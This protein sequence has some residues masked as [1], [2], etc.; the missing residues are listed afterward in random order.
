[1]AAGEGS[2][3]RPLTDTTPKPLLKLCGQTLIEHNI[4]SI[5]SHFDAV[6][7]I[8]KYKKENFQAYFGESLCGKPV[9]YID[10]MDTNGTGAA[11]LSLEGHIEGDFVVISG[12]DLYDPNDILKISHHHGFATLC[13]RVQNP[14]DFGIFQTD[15][16]G[17]AI[18]LIEKP[19][20]AFF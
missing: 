5:L 20:D 17:K 7:I 14:E 18:R 10:Q 15:D 4:T 3:M 16:T 19:T 13:K 9:K 8:V 6:Y 12:D 2:R 11:I 1:M